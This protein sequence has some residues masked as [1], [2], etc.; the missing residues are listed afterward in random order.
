[1]STEPT[2]VGSEGYDVECHEEV[3]A[4]NDPI[5]LCPECV[6]TLYEISGEKINFLR[7]P[8]R[9]EVLKMTVR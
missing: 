9:Q 8:R 4:T 3:D 1:M 6:R 5:K 7:P 2:I